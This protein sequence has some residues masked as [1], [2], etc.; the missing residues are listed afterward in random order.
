M[1][2][3]YDWL[4]EY[5]LLLMDNVFE[6]KNS[7]GMLLGANVKD[8]QLNFFQLDVVNFYDKMVNKGFAFVTF[9]YS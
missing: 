3:G 7:H 5:S 8:R 1:M 6:D 4:L 9:S 2:H